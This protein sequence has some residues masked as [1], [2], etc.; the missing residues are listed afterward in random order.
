MKSFIKFFAALLVAVGVFSSSG[1][2]TQNILGDTTGAIPLAKV[3][4]VAPNIVVGKTDKQWVEKNLGKPTNSEEFVRKGETLL[5]Y[6][7]KVEVPG[8][9]A[10][11][12]AWTQ[13]LGIGNFSAN[14]VADFQVTF[15]KK[16]VVIGYDSTPGSGMGKKGNPI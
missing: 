13:Y 3:T 14:T 1:C 6:N 9:Q 12:V 2:A 4:Q 15:D 10:P 16:G 5:L 11:K 7:Y 8:P